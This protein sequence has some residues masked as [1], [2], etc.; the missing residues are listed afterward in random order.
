MQNRAA[1]WTLLSS[2][3]LLALAP[4][5]SSAGID[6]WHF[7]TSFS[8]GGIY[9]RV[10][11]A[12]TGPFGS[13]FYFEA[14]QPFGYRG[15]ACSSSCYRRGPRYYHHPTCAA[16][17]HHFGLHGYAPG[18]YLEHY[19]PP[20]AYPPSAYYYGVPPA[21]CGATPYYHGAP[22]WWVGY[23]GHYDRHRKPK[24]YRNYRPPSR[25]HHYDHRDQNR[26]DHYQ[27]DRHHRGQDYRDQHSR[28]Q[29]NRG[30]IDRG[31]PGRDRNPRDRDR[32]HREQ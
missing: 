23:L 10:G 12:E 28:D 1:F 32:N 11:Y 30:G 5:P 26:R 27:R 3:F 17:H 2:L 13:S 31:R 6:T 7:G 29:R 14:A 9:F 22:R 24:H 8:V 19:G 21:C 16:M 4:S 15:H 20:I 25:H 18:Y